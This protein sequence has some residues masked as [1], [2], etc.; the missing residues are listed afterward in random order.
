VA[1]LPIRSVA[2]AGL[3]ADKEC[4]GALKVYAALPSAYP[5][6]VGRL[7]EMFAA[8]AATLLFHVQGKEVPERISESLQSSLHS[9]DLIN[10]ACG[11]L[12]G[13]HGFGNDAAL[14]ARMR[15]A[16]E[17]GIPLRQFSAALVAGTPA[18][19]E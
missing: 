8:P 6:P 16:R 11:M 9:R 4:F 14:Q 13:R 15:Q 3:V 17:A 18:R 5:E 12:M 10:R 1:P 2:S 19:P 7:L